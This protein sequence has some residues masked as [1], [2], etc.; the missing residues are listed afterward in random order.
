MT[1]WWFDG[2]IMFVIL[3]S[4]AALAAEDPVHEKSATN[5]LLGKFDIVFTTIFAVE[6]VIKVRE[7]GKSE[8]YPL[9]LSGTRC[10]MPPP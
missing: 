8:V 1:R 7:E 10:D 5:Q 3:L 2:C 6:C 4:S 9:T